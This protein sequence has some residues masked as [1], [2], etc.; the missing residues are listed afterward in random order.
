[1]FGDIRKAK[2]ISSKMTV[3]DYESVSS[4]TCNRESFSFTKELLSQH[5]S[6]SR[7]IQRDY[8]Y[9]VPIVLMKLSSS[10]VTVMSKCEGSG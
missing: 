6:F 10:Q 2:E 4:P 7:V 1:M 9:K 3:H 8:E 5:L